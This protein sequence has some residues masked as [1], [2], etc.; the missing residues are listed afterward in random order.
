MTITVKSVSATIHEVT[1]DGCPTA[2]LMSAEGLADIE[3]IRNEDARWRAIK[4]RA[5]AKKPKH[6]EKKP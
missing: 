1:R 5:L 6:E 3:T 2:Y 4:S